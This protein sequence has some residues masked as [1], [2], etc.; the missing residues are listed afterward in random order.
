MAWFGKKKDTIR[1]EFI[2]NGNEKPFAVSDVPIEQLPDSFELE[3]TFDI[4]ED[5]WSVVQAI[6]D[7]KD[8]F[9]KTGKLKVFLHKIEFINPQNI[10]FSL[11]TLNDSLFGSEA[12]DSTENLL[13]MHEDDWRQIEFISPRYEAEIA[14]EINSITGI[15]QNHRQEA[16]FD[17]IHLRNLIEQPLSDKKISVRDLAENF[18]SVKKYD[19]FGISETKSKAKN[20][21]AFRVEN[22]IDFYGQ[23]TQ[24][25]EILFLCVSG[26]NDSPDLMKKISE[27]YDVIFVDWCR[28]EA[29]K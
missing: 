11:P 12:V 5:Q 20:S 18:S 27:K 4:G 21:F 14:G 17:K 29:M 10:L 8:D 25:G 23:M 22:E 28:A 16:G 24:D 3:T 2:E 13:L 7:N 19:G 9:V 1:V 26:N 15:Y 6:P